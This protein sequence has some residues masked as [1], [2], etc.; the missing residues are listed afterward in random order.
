VSRASL[1]DTWGDL[2]TAANEPQ[3]WR[4]RV[5][6]L[7]PPMAARG[8]AENLFLAL[9]GGMEQI[10]ADLDAIAVG[11]AD[12]EDAAGYVLD[13]AGD[14][15]G[16][17]RGGLTDHEYRRIVA[18][19]RVARRSRG[20]TG[21][22]ARGWRALTG[23]TD[24]EIDTPGLS[25]LHLQARVSWMP[26]TLWLA[27]AGS[28]LRRIVAPGI[29]VEALVYVGTTALY[30]VGPLGYDVGTYAYQIRT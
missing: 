16:E 15:V 22:V 17:A 3:T 21:E 28:V 4:E 13:I 11:I 6:R 26:S 30:D 25:S 23:G 2:V 8:Q 1:A 10:E 20:L 19:G 24:I 18:G 14:L 9:M 29:A 5:A 27:R 7:L 12:V